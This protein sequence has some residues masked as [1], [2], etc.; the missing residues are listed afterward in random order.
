MVCYAVPATA[1]VLSIIF[2]RKINLH[3]KYAQWFTLLFS[4]G[5]V[6]GIVDHLWNGELFLVSEN[7]IKDALLGVV[8]TVGI[9]LAWKGIIFLVKRTPELNS[10]LPTAELK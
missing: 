8:I 4:G 2:R 1:A 7:R 3:T 6:F 5:S 10:Y 9:I